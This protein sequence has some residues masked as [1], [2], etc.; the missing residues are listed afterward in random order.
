VK[1]SPKPAAR[2][3]GWILESSLPRSAEL[4]AHLVWLLDRLEPVARCV[5]S[6]QERGYQ[7]D[8]CC[9]Y[10]QWSGQC[11]PV[12]SP[13]LLARLGAF[14]VELGIDIFGT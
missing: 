11:G 6:F 8:F 13:Q 12:L 9:G 5:R 14:G 4:E 3:G 7:V 1:E 2:R 10:F